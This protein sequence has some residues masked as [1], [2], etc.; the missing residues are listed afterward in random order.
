MLLDDIRCVHESPENTVSYLSSC[1]IVDDE[2]VVSH[3]LGN[4]LSSTLVAPV[5]VPYTIPDKGQP[6]PNLNEQLGAVSTIS[7][8]VLNYFLIR[9]LREAVPNSI[10]LVINN[11]FL[12]A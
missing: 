12:M 7:N 5:Q 8:P 1:C 9:M 4:E 2:S 3:D 6:S 10:V 11:R